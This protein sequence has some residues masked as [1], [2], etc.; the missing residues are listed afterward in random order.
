MKYE[1]YGAYLELDSHIIVYIEAEEGV[2]GFRTTYH[3]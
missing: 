3:R 2:A 1:K